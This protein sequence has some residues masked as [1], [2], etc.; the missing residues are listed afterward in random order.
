M[1]R[2]LAVLSALCAV[3][4]LSTSCNASAVQPSAASVGDI[5][6]TTSQLDA[7]MTALKADV[8]FLCVSNAGTV[9]PTS[10]VGP[11]TWNTTFAAY[12]LTQLIEFGVLAEM[13]K[14][15]HLS[16]PTGDLAQVK[17]EIE[18]S[19]AQ[20]LA[21]L[22]QGSSSI[23]CPGTAASIVSALGPVFGT[24]LIDNQ[25]NVEA[26]S[27]YLAG[28]T[29]QPAALA[30]WENTHASEATES[31]T[32]VLGVASKAQAVKIAAAIKAG[33]SFASEATR[34]GENLGLGAGG[35]FGCVTPDVWSASLRPIVT[36][37]AVGA[38]SKP[39]DDS[40]TWLL[41]TVSKRQ[42]EPL[43]DVIAQIAQL[44]SSAYNSQYSKAIASTP[45][46]VSSVYGSL[47][48]K[49]VTG[50]Y[51]LTV[52]PPSNKACKYAPSAAASGCTTTTAVV[53]G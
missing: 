21:S 45:I 35:A 49:A 29:L 16:T 8:G 1:K 38:V 2:F 32:S 5:A 40:N 4:L 33:A 28:T 7:S 27:A 52:L 53:G 13:M 42:L 3:A 25:L 24:R 18:N 46:S 48:R 17:T 36:G 50:G 15:H 12:V 19:M 26:Y 6:I 51:S 43:S 30:S 14:A 44:E 34:Y 20:S 10:G 47:Q 39:F 22:Q 11:G 31:C 9:P 41:F 23:S 37:L